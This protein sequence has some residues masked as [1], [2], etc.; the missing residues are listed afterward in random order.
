MS[1]D[2]SLVI[3]IEGDSKELRAEIAKIKSQTQNLEANLTSIAK[4]SGVAF[5]ALTATLGSTVKAFASYETAL[6]GVGKTA[7]LSGEELKSFGK[8]IQKLSTDLPFATNELLAIAQSAGQLGVKGRDNLINF[9]QTIAKLGTA[10]DLAGEEAATALTRILNVTGEGV[11]QI[12]KFA[13]VI[14]ALGNNFAATESEIARMT[15]EV[16]RSTSIFGVSSSEAA[17]LG[18]ALKSV[19][20]QAESGG[21]A[22]GRAFREIDAAIRG[23]GESLDT[24]SKLTGIAGDQLKQTFETD[25]VGVF[26]KFSQGLGE[27]ITSGGDVTKVLEEFNLKGDEILKVLPVLAKNSTLV[28]EALALAAKETANATA[29]QKEF[30]IQSK[31][32]ESES[33]KLKN[34][35]VTIAQEIGSF[36]APAVNSAVVGLKDF[37]KQF[38]GLSEGTKKFIAGF[39]GTVTAIAGVTAVGAT[40]LITLTKLRAA[41]LILG[42][43]A[44]R[45]WAAATLGLTLIVPAV[46]SLVDHL[47]GLEVVFDRVKAGIELFARNAI[48]AFNNA[49]IAVNDLIIASKELAVATLEA[50]PGDLFVEKVNKMKASIKELKAENDNLAQSN[51]DLA[52]TYDEILEGISADRMREKVRAQ[53]QA[54]AEEREAARQAELEARAAFEEQKA[55]QDEESRARILEQEEAERERLAE[56]FELDREIQQLQR[57]LTQADI[58]QAS[59]I[60]KT[61]LAQKIAELKKIRDKGISEEK[62][63]EFAKQEE[64]RKAEQADLEARRKFKEDFNKS[65][66]DSAISLGKGLVKEGSA[67]QKALFLVEKAGALSSAVVNTAKA[68]TIALAS[69]PPPVNFALAAANAAAGAVQIAAIGAA[70]FGARDGALVGD[71]GKFSGDRH[72]F[73]LEDGELVVPRRNFDEVVESTARARGFTNNEEGGAS[74]N[75]IVEID[76]KPEAAQFITAKQYENNILGTDRQ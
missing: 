59:E 27:V 24:L 42:I 46:I 60:E 7:D 28:G 13:S 16:A 64:L 69:A 53:E 14:V 48:S 26:Q 2:K 55:R 30:E 36:F 9:T 32:L 31:S 50:L 45:A 47:G 66:L 73:M 65:T 43:A 76:I 29:L 58:D 52:V 35:I 18:T 4:G 56:A 67:A 71:G 74:G 37:L 23:G 19:G 62:K 8:D 54:A 41:F 57:E 12:D 11:G 39:L 20:V 6:L 40:L 49:R 61:K 72:P 15:T 3:R 75:I 22:V 38:L 21:S 10:S 25:A 51:R 44:S 70:A 34:T 5:A 33:S 17:A 1:R 68:I 63:A